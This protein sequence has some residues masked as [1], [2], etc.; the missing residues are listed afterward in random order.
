MVC[1]ANDSF[2]R[3]GGRVRPM[4]AVCDIYDDPNRRQ[5]DWGRFHGLHATA[6][7]FKL[8]QDPDFKLIQCLFSAALASTGRLGRIGDGPPFTYFSRFRFPAAACA[9]R[10]DFW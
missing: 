7:K 1:L 5:T 9:R 8:R 4:G 6:P 2:D 3:G 10:L